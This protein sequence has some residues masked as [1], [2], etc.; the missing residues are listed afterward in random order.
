MSQENAEKAIYTLPKVVSM[1]CVTELSYPLFG[2]NENSGCSILDLRQQ[3]LFL[4]SA[5]KNSRHF[6]W[7]GDGGRAASRRAHYGK[8]YLSPFRHTPPPPS[9]LHYDRI[10]DETKAAH[11]RLNL[12]IQALLASTQFV[13]ESLGICFRCSCSVCNM[14]VRVLVCSH[15]TKSC[16]SKTRIR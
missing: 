12:S 13:Q 11:H 10:V 9:A 8:T 4:V 3:I 6:Q 7:G 2:L 1:T 5:A 14:H 16:D 15:S